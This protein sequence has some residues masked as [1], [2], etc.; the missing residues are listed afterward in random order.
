[1]GDSIS[2]KYRNGMGG[3]RSWGERI[4]KFGGVLHSF[5]IEIGIVLVG[6][7]ISGKILYGGAVSGLGNVGRSLNCVWDFS[8]VFESFDRHA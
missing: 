7:G 8:S 2:G 4:S 1:M 3:K 6:E 5:F